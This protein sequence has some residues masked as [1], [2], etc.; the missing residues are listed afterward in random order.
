M[1]ALATTLKHC[2]TPSDLQRNVMMTEDVSPPSDRERMLWIEARS[3]ERS[4]LE[5][6]L[7]AGCAYS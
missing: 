6:H 7:E 2:P 5:Q 1:T 3:L 4:M